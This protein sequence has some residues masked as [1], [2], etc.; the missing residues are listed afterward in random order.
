MSNIML[1]WP[2]NFVF[3][4][5]KEFTPMSQP[6]HASRDHKEDGEHVSWETHCSVND[7]TVEVNVW[8]QFSLNEVGIIQGDSF[9]FNSN[10]DQLLLTGDLKDLL[11]NLL[12]NLSPGII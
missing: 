4:I 12:N 8:I 1:S 11:S 7:T 2:D 5:I 6:S 9:E 10:F 3:W